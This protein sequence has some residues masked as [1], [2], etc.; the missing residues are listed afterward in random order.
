[1]ILQCEEESLIPDSKKEFSV[2]VH[3][4][5][6]E[7]KIWVR[8]SELILSGTNTGKIEG[9]AVIKLISQCILL[10]AGRMHCILGVL[11]GGS[12]RVLRTRSG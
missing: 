7:R 10:Q 9:H 8:W 1:M 12:L 6:E 2:F 4:D 5:L 3:L 11:S